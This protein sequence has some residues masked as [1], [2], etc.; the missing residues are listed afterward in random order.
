MTSSRDLF[1]QTVA[2]VVCQQQESIN[3][4]I[5]LVDALRKAV[6]ESPELEAA[7]QRNFEEARNSAAAQ[8]SKARLQ[9]L[10][11]T[12]QQLGEMVGAG[13]VLKGHN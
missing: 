10:R 4:L 13:S 11:D 12:I 5:V 1:L 6:A 2:E 9:Q 7:F 8:A 3:E